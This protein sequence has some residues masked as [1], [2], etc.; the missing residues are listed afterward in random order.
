[1]AVVTPPG[2]GCPCTE[3]HRGRLYAHMRRHWDQLRVALPREQLGAWKNV[4]FDQLPAA[5]QLGLM[6]GAIPVGD[7]KVAVQPRQSKSRRGTPGGGTKFHLEPAAML[8]YRQMCR[9]T[10]D[11]VRQ[12]ERLQPEL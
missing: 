4:K 7:G 6:C 12:I 10:A 11:V 3:G 2:V 5:Q 8:T 9:G 1:M